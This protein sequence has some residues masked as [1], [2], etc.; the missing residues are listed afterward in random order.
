MYYEGTLFV[1]VWNVRVREQKWEDVE[2][3]IYK[4]S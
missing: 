2:V 4:Y 1:I 3:R